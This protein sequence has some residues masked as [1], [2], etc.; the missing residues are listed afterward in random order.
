MP[1]LAADTEAFLNLRAIIARGQ[2]ASRV[3]MCSM[4]EYQGCRFA[5]V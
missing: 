3:G 1:A 4:P 5:H 2:V